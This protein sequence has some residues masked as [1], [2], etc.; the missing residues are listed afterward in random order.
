MRG[1]TNISTK[2]AAEELQRYRTE[3]LGQR[4]VCSKNRSRT[5]ES[6]AEHRSISDPESARWRLISLNVASP[7]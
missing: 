3:V 5:Q 6:C 4:H 7:F 2:R 1:G